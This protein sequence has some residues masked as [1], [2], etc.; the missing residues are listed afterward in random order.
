MRYLRTIRQDGN[1]VKGYKGIDRFLK[2]LQI[3]RRLDFAY[4]STKSTKG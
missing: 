2:V 4:V 3:V 1:E